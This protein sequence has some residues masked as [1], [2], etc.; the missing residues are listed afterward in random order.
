MGTVTGIEWTDHTF[1]PWWGCARVSEECRHCYAETWAHRYGVEWG[2]RATRR[3]FG[4]DHWVE[5]ERWARAAEKAGVRRRVFCAS[6]ADV[7]EARADLDAERARL[8]TLIDRT[9][10]LDWLLLTKR[11]EH[12]AGAVPW[13]AAWPANVWI[14]TSVGVQSSAP[15]LDHLRP[16]PAVV[17]FVS[18]EPLLE[19]VAL[20]LDGI[21]WV[22][23]GGESGPGSRPMQTDWARTVRDAAKARGAALFFKQ[24]G[25]THP[26]RGRIGKKIA[27]SMLDGRQWKEFP[28]ARATSPA[29]AP[30]GAQ[31]HLYSASTTK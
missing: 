9:P 7:F 10:A 24:W 29:T 11:P 21:D 8:W 30:R 2:A 22:I 27:G 1:N 16:L 13:G 19:A 5:P 23:V 15:R 20:D 6:M 31:L 28:V 17:R 25:D 3:T 26:E 12:V 4:T 14:G 18:V